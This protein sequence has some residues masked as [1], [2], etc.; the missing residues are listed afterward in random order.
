MYLDLLSS[1][2]CVSRGNGGGGTVGDL[3]PFLLTAPCKKK[4]LIL[5]GDVETNPGPFTHY[6]KNTCEP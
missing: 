2:E 5:A 3:A 6:G 4:L 1:S